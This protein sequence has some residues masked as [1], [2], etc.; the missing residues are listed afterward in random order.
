M[1]ND[2]PAN[3]F[4]LS[5]HWYEKSKP[6]ALFILHIFKILVGLYY[7]FTHAFSPNTWKSHPRPCLANSININKHCLI[8]FKY[9][10]FYTLLSEFWYKSSLIPDFKMSTLVKQVLIKHSSSMIRKSLLPVARHLSIQ[11]L[12]VDWNTFKN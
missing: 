9:F 10:K 2:Q 6:L 5:K 4:E 3:D 11:G 7:L 8:K 1:K 12:V